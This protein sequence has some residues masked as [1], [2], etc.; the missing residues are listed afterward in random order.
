MQGASGG[1]AGRLP[2]DDERVGVGAGR[3]K[4]LDP[5]FPVN[6]P[7]GMGEAAP[8]VEAANQ[9]YRPGHGSRVSE[10]DLAQLGTHG[11]SSHA[12][13]VNRPLFL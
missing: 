5:P 1:I 8:L 11:A 3:E 13:V 9:R 4:D 2:V 12:N 7:E 6:A 10:H